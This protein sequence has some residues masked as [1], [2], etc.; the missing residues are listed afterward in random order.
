MIPYRNTSVKTAIQIVTRMN[1]FEDRTDKRY[2][3][4]EVA[5][6]LAPERKSF[7]R[8]IYDAKGG[9]EATPV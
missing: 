1:V 5:S 9:W 6:T 2:G 4:E 8:C 3:G 7:T